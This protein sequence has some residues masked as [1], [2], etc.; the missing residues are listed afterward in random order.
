[1]LDSAIVPAQV[2]ER[3]DRVLLE[4]REVRIL[5]VRAEQ[6]VSKVSV[7]DA[8]VG[9]FYDTH[10]SDFETPE[11]VK[12]EYLVLSADS[13]A[14]QSTVSDADIMAFYEQNK[15][16]YGVEEQRRASHILIAPEGGDKSAA[17]KKAEGVLATV[18]AN[19]NDFAKLAKE[20]SKDPGSAAQGG[21]LGFFG[22]GMMVKPFEDAAFKLKVG[23]TSDIVE[24]D[25]GF[26][27]IR[28]T[29]VKPAQARPLV[30]VRGEI[31]KDLR[32]QQA[33]KRYAEAAEQFTNLVYEQSDSLQ[34]VADKLGLK[35][36]T[37]DNVTRNLPPSAPNQPQ[38]LNQRV[39]EALFA[40]DALKSRRN[41]QAIEV[42]PNTLVAARVVD[43]R[44]AAVR[45]FEEVKT[46]IRQRLE[47][48]E[49][50]KLARAAG[51]EKLAELRK[52][53]NE[54]GF[55]PVIA[56]SRRSPQGMP[57]NLLNEVLRTRADKLPTYVGAEMEG[58]GY[59]IANVVS[60]KEA[61]AQLPAQREAERRAVQRQA[62]AADEVAY[63]EGLRVRH[64]ATV[65]KPE[66]RR[67]P[68]KAPPAEAPA[69]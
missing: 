49:A 14:G 55:S 34:P 29:E 37:Q 47:R 68:A 16:R 10:K 28:L 13:L 27:I 39:V 38:L 42:A 61:S 26:H 51:E 12:V 21:D 44:P 30:E 43:H 4:Q 8:Q 41:T 31:E 15:G 53:A 50:A 2:A 35:V 6:Y 60:A 65:L 56:V 18:K 36:I 9:A 22:K 20:Q 1:V 58:A 59:L 69:K 57:A 19:P 63:A 25:F 17:R 40:E 5:T 67:E 52:Q 33:Q 11:S 62:A 45:P 23:E 54:T 7:S 32:T 64:K 66:F 24:T 48:D 3:I 46:A